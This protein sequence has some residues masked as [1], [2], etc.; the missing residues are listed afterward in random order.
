MSSSVL[1]NT[2]Q[3]KDETSERARIDRS[4]SSPV[5]FL[6]ASA[7]GWLLLATLF[8][9][10]AAIKL[11]RPEFLSS[12]ACTSYGRIWPA[13]LHALGYGWASLAGLATALWMMGRLCRVA[14]GKSGL[15]LTGAALWN[16]GVL[17]G[18]VSILAGKNTGFAWLEFP[19]SS[20]LLLLAG[21]MLM[22][23]PAALLFRRR[24]GGYVY[25][26]IWYLVGA[27]F[28]FP[29]N[30]LSAQ[31]LAPKLS[32]IMHS[33][34]EASFASNLFGL[35]FGALGLG[36]I[37]YL[38]P[39][40]I[41]RPIYSHALA[42]VGFWL[43]ALLFGWSATTRLVGGPLPAWQITLGI[44]A[45]ILLLIPIASV[46]A[47]CLL[48]L[49]GNFH[50][51]YNSPTIRFSVF[52]V[53]AWC[54]AGILT[55]AACFRS[56]ARIV[57]FTVL[58]SALTHLVLYGF[59][60]MVLF[61]SIYYIVPRLTGCEWVSGAFIRL[62]FWGASYGIGM[63]AVM[64]VIGGFVQGAALNSAEVAPLGVLERTTPFLVAQS[65]GWLL[66]TASHFVMAFHFGLMLFR[67]GKPG[68]QPTLFASLEEVQS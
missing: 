54:V 24:R 46:T 26:T 7:L 42:S 59:F 12:F 44:T 65:I 23:V 43:Y 64:L 34:V 62:H 18:V 50:Q 30:F 35:W 29:W 48:T 21:Y 66:L 15:L 63:I 52:G 2:G 11:H 56:V 57:H 9:F 8:G 4:L 31:V 37:Y 10:G 13:Y 16:L 28:W 19:K 39:K 60:S 47:N 20:T 41:G 45:S 49:K 6:Y 17:V 53:I 38:V 5:L 3:V 67:R 27:L 1:E 32:G 14:L 51:V 33:V 68:G 25:I 61:A 40:V 22:A 36:F 58:D 55:T